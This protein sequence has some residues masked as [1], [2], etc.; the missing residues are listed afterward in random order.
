LGGAVALMSANPE[1][2]GLCFPGVGPESGFR[3]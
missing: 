1:G 2:N 3:L